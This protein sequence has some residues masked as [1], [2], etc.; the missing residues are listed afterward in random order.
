MGEWG[1]ETKR[2]SPPLGA[3][4]GRWRTRENEMER[5][6]PGGRLRR[7]H[8]GLTPD[9]WGWARGQ[10][11]V[12]VKGGLGARAGVWPGGSQGTPSSSCR[13]RLVS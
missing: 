2:A 4:R 13:S 5:G 9:S 3:G 10:P 6:W 7:P 11:G 1:Q 8:G 12:P